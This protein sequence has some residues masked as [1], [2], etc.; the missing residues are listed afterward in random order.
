VEAPQ[1][2]ASESTPVPVR[3]RLDA[4]LGRDEQPQPETA[5]TRLRGDLI[6]KS[7]AATTTACG[8][9][10]DLIFQNGFE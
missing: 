3:F 7:T 2:R 6:A 5:G 8:A 9:V 4:E 10:L 1:W